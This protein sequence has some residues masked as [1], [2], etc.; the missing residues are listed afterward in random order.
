MSAPRSITRLAALF[1]LLGTTLLPGCITMI[2]GSGELDE[3]SVQRT[4]AKDNEERLKRMREGNSVR[5]A[6]YNALNNKL[7]GGDGGEV[8]PKPTI[9]ELERRTQRAKSE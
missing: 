7:G 2:A 6:E 5:P 9:E 8:A 3:D 1:A 4:Q